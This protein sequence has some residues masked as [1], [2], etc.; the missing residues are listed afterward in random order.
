[1]PRSVPKHNPREV[2]KRFFKPLRRLI[3]MNYFRFKVRG[4]NHIPTEGQILF[5]ANHSGWI[6]I[7]ALFMMMAI[8]D[9]AG[10]EYL[11]YILVHDLLLRVPLVNDLLKDLGSIPAH[12]LHY[13][14][15]PLDP[16][17]N[18]IAIFPEG[19]DGNSK[20]FWKA[21]H[22]QDWK[23]GFV[24]LAIQRRAKVVPVIIVG[25]EESV[26]VAR[27]LDALKP[28]LGSVAPLPVS[29]LPLPS[30][31]KIQFLEPLDFSGYDPELIHSKEACQ[32]IAA[33]VHDIVQKRLEK[34]AKNHPLLWLSNWVDRDEKDDETPEEKSAALAEAGIP[35]ASAAPAV[36]PIPAATAS[37]IATA[38]VPAEL[39]NRIVDLG[40][41]RPAKKTRPRRATGSFGISKDDNID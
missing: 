11:P 16:K 19:A 26:P 40:S 29:L 21:Y 39:Q 24:R 6:A 7:D 37:V 1:M 20:P 3:K 13:G 28:L 38:E 34:I 32:E 27:T 12:W 25:G 31:W 30:R 15:E 4:A 22:M 23:S 5:V 8:Y 9:T 14:G 17:I 2:N 18:P 36:D 41:A 33:Q 35:E 10:P